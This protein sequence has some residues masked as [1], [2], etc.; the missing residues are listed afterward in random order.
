MNILCKSCGDPIDFLSLLLMGEKVFGDGTASNK[1]DCWD[2]YIIKNP[3]GSEPTWCE[4]LERLGC[5]DFMKY[6]EESDHGK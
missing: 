3:P 4:V 1:C 2:C 5:L 6:P